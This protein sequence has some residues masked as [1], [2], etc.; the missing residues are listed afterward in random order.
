M[1]REAELL[2]RWRAG[3]T[4]AGQELLRVCSDVLY[5]FLANKVDT[6]HEDIAQRTL[7][8]CVEKVDNIRNAGSFRAYLLKAA[9]HELASY[10]RSR[11][12][13]NLRFDSAVVS[14]AQ[15]T[16]E[17]TPSTVL[18]AVE[19]HRHLLLAVRRLPLD[20]QITLELFYWEGTPVAEIAEITEVPVGTVKSRL[21][22]ARRTVEHALADVASQADTF[23]ADDFER[24]A[25]E[26]RH[27]LG[28]TTP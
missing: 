10:Y 16:G 27:F 9:R 11:A 19:H 12:R 18:A 2:Q 14:V 15:L 21:D 4:A 1:E 7:L 5:R 8:A 13:S 6:D 3:D 24:W 28:R 17:A 26:L 23:S 25:H 22:R 20:L